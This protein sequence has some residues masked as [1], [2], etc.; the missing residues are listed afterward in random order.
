VPLLDHYEKAKMLLGNIGEP[1]T[2]EITRISKNMF[3]SMW[4][5]KKYNAELKDKS[6]RIKDNN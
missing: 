4:E 1:K 3:E 6:L 2:M 5:Q